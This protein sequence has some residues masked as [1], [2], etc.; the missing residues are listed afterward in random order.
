[1]DKTRN[2]TP[3]LTPN[4]T[5]DTI[6]KSIDIG[7]SAQRVYDL[8]SRPGWWINEGSITENLVSAEGDVNTVTHPKY[9]SFRIQTVEQDPPRY[10]A[11]RWLGGDTELEGEGGAPKNLVEFWVEERPG[12]VSLRVKESGFQALSPDEEVRR[13]NYEAN[14]QGWDQELEAARAYVEGAAA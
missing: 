4:I 3:N 14:L 7:A 13:R 10:V 5:P 9:G 6:E 2:M 1:M 8:V 11:F 12:G